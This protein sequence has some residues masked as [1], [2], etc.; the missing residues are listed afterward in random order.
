MGFLYHHDPLFRMQAIIYRE[1]LT[2]T[3][4][5]GEDDGSLIWRGFVR[6]SMMM[7]VCPR[8]GF[9]K[10]GFLAVW[11]SPTESGA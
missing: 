7:R 9:G 2:T 8:E 5:M 10:E 1:H 11:R 4:I 3:A 6:E